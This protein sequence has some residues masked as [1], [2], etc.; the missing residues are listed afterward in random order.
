MDAKVAGLRLREQAMTK[1]SKAALSLALVVAFSG[2]GATVFAQ[3]Q[4]PP[5]LTVTNIG[6]NVFWVR[7]GGGSNDGVGANNAFIVG[8]SGV[9]VVDTKTM[10]DV[11]KG[12]IAEI[13][14]TTLKP[15]DT[16]ILTH[17]DEDHVNGLPVF[18]AGITIIAQENCKKE[19][20]TSAKLGYE[21]CSGC[22]TQGQVTP[23]QNRLPTKTFA[24]MEALTIDGVHIRLYHWGPAHTKGKSLDDIKAAFGGP[25]AGQPA[26]IL[27]E[28]IYKEVSKKS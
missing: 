18:P 5:P 10:V 14:K 7:G 15:I 9:I 21:P 16:V 24:N 28:V 12:V 11:E 4:P 17:S 3:Q 22:R 20:E 13:A 6:G 25:P 19:M 1:M 26:A 27:I 2:F 8:T 23:S